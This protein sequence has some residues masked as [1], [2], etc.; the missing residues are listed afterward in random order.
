[1]S[2]WQSLAFSPISLVGKPPQKLS[3]SFSHRKACIH[4]TNHRTRTRTG[5]SPTC[6]IEPL[7][8]LSIDVELDVPFA[9]G[10]FGEVFIGVLKDTGERV[11]LKRARAS[12]TARLLFS[13]ERRINRKLDKLFDNSDDRRW[14]KFLGDFVKDS[15]SFLVWQ[16]EGEG[17]TLADYFSMRPL[18]ELC[19]ALNVTFSAFDTLQIALFRRVMRTLLVALYEIHSQGIVHRDVKPSN[20]L[21]VPYAETPLQLIDFG[22][23]CETRSLLWSPGVHTLDPLYAA[24]ETRV[25]FMAPLHFDVFSAA[26]VG[27]SALMPSYT[28]EGRI[29]EFRYALDS[30]D[31]DFKRLQERSL[32]TNDLSIFQSGGDLRVFFSSDS[33]QATQI[34]ELLCGMFHKSPTKRFSVERA[35][36]MLQYI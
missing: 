11:V 4:S 29:R 3:K 24:P 36:E 20:I 7:N 5:T 15:Q 34:F 12:S 21:V 8:R 25:N 23:A 1:M 16:L 27:I 10:S 33:P 26:M 14:P 19:D 2:P 13:K 17:M 6:I 22:S 28:S 18:P 32:S 9:S 31:Y 30:A 35:L